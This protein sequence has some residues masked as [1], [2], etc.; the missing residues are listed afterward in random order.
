MLTAS[1]LGL[2]PNISV[3]SAKVQV[4]RIS[5]IRKVEVARVNEI[6]NNNIEKP[7]LGLFGT[8]KINVLKLN[9]VLDNLK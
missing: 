6:I 1:G 5:K 3:E 9:I 4:D 7:F 8:E 2:D